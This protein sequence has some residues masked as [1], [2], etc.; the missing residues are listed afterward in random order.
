MNL[1]Q[2]ARPAWFL[3]KNMH[4]PWTTQVRS[5]LSLL[6]S[7]RSSLSPLPPTPNT[8]GGFPFMYWLMID[9]AISY[10]T[11]TLQITWL[12]YNNIISCSMSRGDCPEVIVVVVFLTVHKSKYWSCGCGNDFGLPPMSAVLSS[13]YIAVTH[14]ATHSSCT[15]TCTTHP[16]LHTP[17]PSTTLLCI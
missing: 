14:N 17:L 16:A 4:R 11:I 2:V 8:L 12:S 13:S 1:L 15:S 3:M 5:S 7:A 6:W 10:I 9:C